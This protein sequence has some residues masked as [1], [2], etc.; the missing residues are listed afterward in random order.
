VNE[1]IRS[2]EMT[3]ANRDLQEWSG[4]SHASELES[5]VRNIY[6]SGHPGLSS[7]SRRIVPVKILI[8]PCKI[9]LELLP[10]IGKSV[11]SPIAV[12]SAEGRST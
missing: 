4:F 3:L 6:V 9:L 10:V 2:A 7:I 1:A 12:A 11:A 5:S 8:T